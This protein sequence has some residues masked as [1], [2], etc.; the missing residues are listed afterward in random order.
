MAAFGKIALG[1]GP[2]SK[3]RGG[4]EEVSPYLQPPYDIV[5]SADHRLL[6]PNLRVTPLPTKFALLR[7]HSFF[8][9]PTSFQFKFV[10]SIPSMALLQLY[11]HVRVRTSDFVQK[12]FVLQL[13]TE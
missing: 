8:G 7:L 12:Y 2:K 9:W 5:Q 10:Y 1:K 3:S 13:Y 11:V 4:H 6:P